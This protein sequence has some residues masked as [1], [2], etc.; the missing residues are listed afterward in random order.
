MSVILACFRLE[1]RTDPT[2]GEAKRSPK[3]A[4]PGET[5]LFLDYIAE[6]LSC[7]SLFSQE[8]TT[9]ILSIKSQL[10]L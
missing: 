8:K 7:L 9:H 10:T 5:L 2:P 6:M 3:Q 1:E 4:K